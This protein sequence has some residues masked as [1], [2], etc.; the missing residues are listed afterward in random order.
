MGRPSRAERPASDR[1][2][3]RITP[4]EHARVRTAAAVNH[5]TVSE[6]VRDALSLAVED[7]LDDLRSVTTE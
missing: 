5:Q 3:V 2:P 7:C 6:F 4:D 1:L